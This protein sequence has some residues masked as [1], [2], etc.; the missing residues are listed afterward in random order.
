M[1]NILINGA[2]GRMGKVT[3]N[4]VAE[5]KHLNLVGTCIRGE[6]LVEKIKTYQPDI[7][8][9]FTHPESVFENTKIV[10][11]AGVRPVV[12]TTGL[13]STQIQ[14]LYELCAAKKLGAIIAPNF[15]IGAILSMHFAKIAAKYF[16]QAEIVEAH[17]PHKKDAP[18]GTAIKTA[19]LIASV[20][21]QIVNEGVHQKPEARGFL[22]NTI[23]IHS[24]RIA[25]LPTQQTIYFGNPGEVI[26]IEHQVSDREAYMSGIL[27]ACEKVMG[28]DH[29]VY[30]LE[31]LLDFSE[32]N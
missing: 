15:S 13:T 3:V 28:L 26:N 30:G 4:T 29:L 31:N 2:Q 1:I 14:T 21:Q 25:G 8:I 11:N 18:S 27:L 17:H 24:L 10:L 12:G 23:P 5:A 22:V 19:E 20:R 9:D 7:V 16:K 6:N 32:T